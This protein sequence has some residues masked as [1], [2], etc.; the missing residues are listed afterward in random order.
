MILLIS[1][2][3]ISIII[4]KLK[5]EYSLSNYILICNNKENLEVSF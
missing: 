1:L 2:V 4:E 5:C 3:K